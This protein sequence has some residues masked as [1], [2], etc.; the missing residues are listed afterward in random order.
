M[1][2]RG[3]GIFVGLEPIDLRWGFERLAA[4]WRIVRSVESPRGR[5]I[6]ARRMGL[7]CRAS[8]GARGVLA[9]HRRQTSTVGRL[10]W[11]GRNLTWGV[12]NRA[13]AAEHATSPDG[14][15]SRSTVGWAIHQ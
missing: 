14:S 1:T 6:E 13:V 15:P 9:G 7:V 5:L 8:C 12:P 11:N 2:P 4:W 3:V 10:R